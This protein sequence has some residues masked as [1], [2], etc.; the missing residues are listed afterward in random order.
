MAVP[1][2]FAALVRPGVDPV[3]CVVFDGLTHV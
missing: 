2:L 1:F 3:S